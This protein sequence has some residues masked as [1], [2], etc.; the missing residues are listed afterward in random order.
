MTST[1]LPKS[2]WSDPGV[3]LY[4][5]LCA[6]AL[7]VLWL[8]LGQQ[9]VGLF[10]FLPVLVGVLGVVLRF[11]W[12]PALVILTVAGA[13]FYEQL[14]MGRWLWH[15]HTFRSGFRVPD[16]LLCGSVL[17]FISAHYRLQGLLL[18]IMPVDPRRREVLRQRPRSSR[19]LGPVMKARRSTNL[20]SPTE[21]SV[22]LLTLPL[23]VLLG[24]FL[25]RGLSVEREFLE[26][27]HWVTRLIL[28]FWGL[29]VVLYLGA[30]FLRQLERWRMSREEGKLLLQDALWRATRAGQRRA[31]RWL[32]WLRLLPGRKEQ[33]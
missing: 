19:L 30:T 26:L 17:L 7:V 22:L 18:N 10:S 33:V 14:V 24:Q 27:P 25:W 8:A 13:M 6:L 29:G 31:G 20:V 21:L 11:R 16:M 9:G 32:A 23:W 15:W 2:D 5:L 28:L 4:T 3:L 1:P 12:T